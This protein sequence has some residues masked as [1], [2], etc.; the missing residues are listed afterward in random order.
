MDSSSK[1]RTAGAPALGI[2]EWIS[3]VSAIALVLLITVCAAL[4][5]AVLRLN[6]SVRR[7]RVALYL[8]VAILGLASTLLIVYRVVDPPIFFD[9]GALIVEGAVKLPI[10]LALVAAAGITLGACLALWEASRRP[11]ARIAP[12][13]A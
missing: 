7:P 13:R 1:G 9:D 12:S 8:P 11:A 6:G 3:G 4:V 10:V 2:G 5:V